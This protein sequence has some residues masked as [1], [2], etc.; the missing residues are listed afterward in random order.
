M[1]RLVQLSVII[2]VLMVARRIIFGW[3]KQPD[4]LPQLLRQ[5]L[6]VIL[7]YFAYVTL[8]MLALSFVSGK[9]FGAGG[10]GVALL[11]T[12]GAALYVG[13]GVAAMWWFL[14]KSEPP[15]KKKKR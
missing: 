6:D 10:T 3:L 4:T 7:A 8:G 14:A 2:A 12:V 11:L 1:T 9:G 13:V 5:G 15:R